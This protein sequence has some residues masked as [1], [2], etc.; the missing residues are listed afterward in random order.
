M[1]AEGGMVWWK[2]VSKT[3]TCGIGGHMER[4]QGVGPSACTFYLCVLGRRRGHPALVAAA[5]WGA[6]AGEGAQRHGR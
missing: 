2:A 3:A 4:S 6:Q 5:E 1:K